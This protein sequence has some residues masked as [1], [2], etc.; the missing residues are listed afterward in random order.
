MRAR[1]TASIVLA[2]ALA[3]GTTGCTFLTPQ[4]TTKI[5]ESSDGVNGSVGNIEV[6]G[7]TIISGTGS[8]GN[9]LTT[10]V[11]SGSSAVRVK[12][13]RGTGSDQAS[14]YVKVP[15]GS[16]TQIGARGQQIVLFQK[17]HAMVGSLYPVFFQYGDHT[18]VRLL[19]PVLNGTLS[20][21]QH[22]LPS[23]VQPTATP[24]PGASATP[25]A[26]PGS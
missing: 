22:L 11:N 8:V 23:E 6:R 26:T 17:L 3:L 24:T 21:Y 19:V 5:Q 13:E 7:A 12:I 18:G 20:Q 16:T 10:F 4:E 2:A 25:T 1:I 9:L 14:Y 15:A